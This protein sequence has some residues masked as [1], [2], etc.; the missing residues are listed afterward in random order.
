[1]LAGGILVWK[2]ITVPGALL[3]LIGGLAGG[4]FGLPSLL[5]MLLASA[6]GNWAYSLP[7]LPF[8]LP[9]PIA[10]LVLAFMSE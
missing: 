3:I 10:S 4:F 5:W 6:F 7:L 2:R 9:I 8:G 1:M